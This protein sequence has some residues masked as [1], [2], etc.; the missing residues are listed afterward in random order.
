MDLKEIEDMALPT[1]KIILYLK[2]NRKKSK[3]KD[4]N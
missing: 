4:L 3:N 2:K 1:K